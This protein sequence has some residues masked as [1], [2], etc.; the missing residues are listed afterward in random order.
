VLEVTRH[1]LVGIGD[2]V[3]IWRTQGTQHAVAGVIAEAA[4]TAAPSIRAVIG[5][6]PSRDGLHT[7]CAQDVHARVSVDP[8]SAHEGAGDRGMGLHQAFAMFSF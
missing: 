3:Y 1:D 2:Q 6:P 8:T 4:V 5:R 7:C